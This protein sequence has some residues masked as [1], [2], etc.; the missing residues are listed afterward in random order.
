MKVRLDHVTNS[1][2]SS[3]ICEVCGELYSER[4][5]CLSDAEMM[6]CVN[7]HVVCQSHLGEVPDDEEFPHE[8]PAEFCLICTL[9]HIR[10]RDM[11]DYVLKMAGGL[12]P[13]TKGEVAHEIREGNRNLEA[14]R[15]WLNED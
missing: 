7:S 6:E 10:D 4:D 12:F 9:E 2:T 11:L 14:L 5:A 13:S 3:Y 1:S 15:E 8:V